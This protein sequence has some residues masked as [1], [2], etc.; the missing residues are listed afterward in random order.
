MEDSQG[1]NGEKT[2]DTEVN[3][4][5]TSTNTTLK[6]QEILQIT[7]TEIGPRLT[8][9]LPVSTI[10]AEDY[11]KREPVSFEFAE[12]KSS[13]VLKLLSKS[14]VTRATGL[15]QISNKVLKPA[16]LLQSSAIN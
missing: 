8:T 4:I 11:L 15:D 10:N 2:A 3:E 5:L 1:Y 9:N 12:I 6:M 14:D 13:R 7:F 16:G